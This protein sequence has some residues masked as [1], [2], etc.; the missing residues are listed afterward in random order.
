MDEEADADRYSGTGTG[1]LAPPWRAKL[2][3][4]LVAE[5]RTL[6]VLRG[7]LHQPRP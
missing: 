4:T 5:A 3:K 1:H 7:R 6:D 2:H